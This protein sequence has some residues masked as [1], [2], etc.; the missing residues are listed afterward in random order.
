MIIVI[1]A[2][3]V[4]G[5]ISFKCPSNIF[6]V[7]RLKKKKEKKKALEFKDVA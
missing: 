3:F 7:T 1:C 4:Y 5:N 2:S 6:L